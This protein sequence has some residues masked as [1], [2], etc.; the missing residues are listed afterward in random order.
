MEEAILGG[1]LLFIP[2]VTRAFEMS[3]ASHGRFTSVVVFNY[4]VM[5]RVLAMCS[6]LVLIGVFVASALLLFT[7]SAL[8]GEGYAVF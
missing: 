5:G 6:R 2:Y 8:Y 1:F 3:M 7:W 4:L